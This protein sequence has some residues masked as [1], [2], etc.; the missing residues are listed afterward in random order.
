MKKPKTVEAY[1]QSQ[2]QWKE[3]LSRL[4]SLLL[5]TGLEETIKWSFPVYMLDGKNVAGLGAFQSHFGIWFFQGALLKDQQQ[6][7]VNAQEG[8][9]Q[10]MRQLRF[11]S[12]EEVDEQLVRDY[13]AE[14]IRN[15]KE[16]REIKPPRRKPLAI[17]PELK[18]ALDS[19]PELAES[20]SQLSHGRKRDYA[21]YISEAKRA[22]T[23]ASRLEKI[24]PMIL[25]GK[26]LNDK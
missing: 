7:L 23:K 20:F 8:K 19:Q 10:A 22:E 26:G 9:T 5:S 16:G 21:G 4:R 6:R 3:P 13:L 25:V 24:I 18:Q 14:A 15:Q 17:P 2:E 11:S 12:A 1:I